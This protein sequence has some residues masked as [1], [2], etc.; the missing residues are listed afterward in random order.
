MVKGMD[1]VDVGP[2]EEAMNAHN[3]GEEQFILIGQ[4]AAHQRQSKIEVLVVATEDDFIHP[5]IEDRKEPE[6]IVR[7]VFLLETI[8]GSD[9]E[10][11]NSSISQCQ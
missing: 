7:R 1:G 11:S 6:T 4:R 8:G 10:W 9:A 5:F 3:G 2:A